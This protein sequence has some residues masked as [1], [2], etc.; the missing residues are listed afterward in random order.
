M[1]GG[2]WR[3]VVDASSGEIP[4]LVFIG[5][6]NGGARVCRDL[7]WKRRHGVVLLLATA[8]APEGNLRS[9]GKAIEVSSCLSPW[10]II[11]E[12]ATTRRPVD[13]G[14]LAVWFC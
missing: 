8:L 4:V 11:S 2:H 5:A 3:H 12:S 14:I 9:A 7:S 13:G 6:D 1:G 10:G